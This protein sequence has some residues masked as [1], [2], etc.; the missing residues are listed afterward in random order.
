MRQSIRNWLWT[1][2]AIFVLYVVVSM[3]FFNHAT[4]LI[5]GMPPL[6]FWFTLMPL[7]TPIFLGALYISDKKTNPQW[8]EEEY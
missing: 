8:N 3:L 7:A 4:Y 1:V 6:L 2:I 5:L